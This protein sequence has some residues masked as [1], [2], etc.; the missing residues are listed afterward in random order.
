ML[1]IIEREARKFGETTTVR[2]IP[3]VVNTS[4]KTVRVIWTIAL[5]V[6]GG[7]MVWQLSQIMIRFFKY[8]HTTVDGESK[9][10]AV[11]SGLVW[12]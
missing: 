3:R 8:E 5:V 12:L 4:D 2:G 9:N 11:S 1:T 7:M 10:N 6:A